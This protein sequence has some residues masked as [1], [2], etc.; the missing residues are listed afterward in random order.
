MRINCGPSWEAKHAA[1]H[2]WHRWFAWRPV[3]I[4]EGDCRWLETIERK[5]KFWYCWRHGLWDWEYRET[6]VKPIP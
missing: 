4:A 5:G 6:Q 2:E 3:R 1:K